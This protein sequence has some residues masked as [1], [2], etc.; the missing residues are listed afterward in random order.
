MGRAAAHTG[1]VI[2]WDQMKSS[3]FQF[4]DDI[5]AMTFET[6][7]PIKANPDGSYDAPLPGIT[8]EV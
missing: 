5:D 3:D 2:T 8:V 4:I 6:P 1:K 7:P